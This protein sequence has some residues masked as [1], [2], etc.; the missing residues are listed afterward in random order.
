MLFDEFAKSVLETIDEFAERVRTIGQNPVTSPQEML[1][2]A[3]VKVA[4][5]GQTMREMVQ[6]GD[7]NLALN[8][9]AT[10]S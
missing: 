9:F 4:G 7:E 5:R 2:T 10:K 6:E 1:A 3:S 8:Y